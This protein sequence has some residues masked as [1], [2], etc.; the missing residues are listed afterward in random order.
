MRGVLH[1]E[2]FGFNFSADIN[3]YQRSDDCVI[4]A[5]QI[6]ERPRRLSKTSA[7]APETE[8]G[9]QVGGTHE[10]TFMCLSSSEMWLTRSIARNHVQSPVFFLKGVY[11]GRSLYYLIDPPRLYDRPP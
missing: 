2:V 11:E 4:A 10:H 3:P 5:G 1:A 8:R 9:T 7:D 6:T